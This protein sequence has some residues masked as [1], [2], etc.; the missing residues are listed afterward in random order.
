MP[1]VV[2]PKPPQDAE[3]S[4]KQ[5]ADVAT[6]GRAASDPG[7]SRSVPPGDAGFEIS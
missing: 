3:K 5:V 2:S 6:G 1:G 4:L 7:D